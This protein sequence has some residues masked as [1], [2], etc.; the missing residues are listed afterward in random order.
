MRIPRVYADTSVYG[1]AFDEEFATASREFFEQVRRGRFALV[2]STVVREEL[3]AAPA[4]LRQFFLRWRSLRMKTK[5]F[6]C[7][8]MKRRGALEVY[9]L[10]KDLSPDE[11]VAFWKAETDKLREEQK[12]MRARRK[13]L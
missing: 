2:T 5:T 6:D 7:V 11:Q 10:L 13:V 3:E 4:N 1:G 12:P 8:E 9:E